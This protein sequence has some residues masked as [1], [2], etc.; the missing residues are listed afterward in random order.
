[1]SR[2]KANSRKI[3]ILATGDEI[4][5]GDILNSNAKEI[6]S[7]LFDAQMHI[8]F[9]LSVADN[10]EE[11]EQAIRFLLNNHDALIITGGLGPTSDDLTRYALANT[12]NRPLQFD[13]VIW[14]A[15][16]NRLKQ[17]GYDHPPEGNRQQALFPEG[18]NILPNPAGTAAGCSIKH[19][20]Q[21][22]FMLPGPPTE[23][24]PLVDHHVLPQLKNAHFAEQNYHQKW[25][26]FGVSEGHIAEKLDA[27]V[28]P[29]QCIT[30]YRLCYP[31]IE[32]KLYSTN[33]ED[34]EKVL[35]LIQQEIKPFLIGNGKELASEQLKAVLRTYPSTLTL[36]DEATGGALQA[37][38]QTPETQTKLHFTTA[39]PM[40]RISGLEAY[41]KSQNIKE[42][43]LQLDF[44]I[45]NTHTSNT[46]TIPFRGTRVKSYAVEFIASK[47]LEM[48]Q[49]RN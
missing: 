34:F 31:Y 2:E 7:R 22:I 41:W 28:K 42:T 45:E 32:F 47:L 8:G 46:Y 9:H 10:I 29:F 37:T 26:L 16:C 11:I 12:L 18:A 6:A 30:G 27:I 25:F 21:F 36:Q 33:K 19:N 48:I 49:S 14:E 3:A 20:T 24:L 35:P 5:H 13:A 43:T 15:I 44:F 40:L 17:L 1:M 4:I 39:S 38:L 23:C